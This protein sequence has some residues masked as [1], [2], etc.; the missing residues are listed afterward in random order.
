MVEALQQEAGVVVRGDGAL[1]Q[2]IEIGVHRLRS[3][4]PARAGGTDTGPTPYQLLLAAL[5]S[6]ISMTVSLYARRKGWPLDGVEVRLRHDKIH[7][8]DCA[9][10]ETREGKIDRIVKDVR[11]QGAL[12]DAQRARLLEIAGRCPVART[13]QS[14][15]QIV[16]ESDRSP[17]A[18]TLGSP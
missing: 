10:C 8:S 4:E 6:C 18:P 11:L 15:I 14:E 7:A 2:E 13:L 3:D 17:A 16:D 1:A 5:G 12:D 9:D